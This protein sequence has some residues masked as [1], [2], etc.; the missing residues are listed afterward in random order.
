[1]QGLSW[2]C[3]IYGH[4]QEDCRKRIRENQPCKGLNRSTCWPKQKQ[5]PVGE[6]EE[7]QET[8]GAVGEIYTGDLANI[9]SG[10]QGR[11]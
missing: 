1:M 4:R 5:S 9:F 7:H 10:F 11:G 8:Q 2:F 6:G 3:K